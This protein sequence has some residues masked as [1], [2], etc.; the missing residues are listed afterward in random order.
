MLLEDLSKRKLPP[1]LMADTTIEGWPSRRKEIIEMF[2]K[3]VY[4]YSP[5]PPT[6]VRG[7]QVTEETRIWDGN[8]LH[9]RISINFTTQKGDFSFPI[10]LLTPTKRENSPLI[11]YISFHEYPLN[12]HL[13]LK[14]LPVDDIVSSGYAVAVM[15][16]N[17]V[18][19]DLEPDFTTGLAAMYDRS[20]DDGTLWGKISMWAWAASRVMDFVQ[21]LDYVDKKRIFCVGHS[22]LGKTALWCGVQDERFAATVSND[23]GCSGAAITRDKQ[24]ETVKDITT[25]FPFWFC[26]NYHKYAGRE[27]EMPFD[28]HQLLAAMAPRLLYVASADEDIWAD[29]QSEFLSCVAANEAYHLLDKKGIIHKNR[30]PETGESLH[31]G[32]IGYHLRAGTHFLARFDWKQILLYMDRALS[33]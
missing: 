18:T 4:G 16:Y 10:D 27:H 6:D 23:S 17:D 8:V 33:D 3:E 20:S 29:P 2:A 26:K 7:E 15:H 12:D 24:G 30:Y 19:K 13:T 9:Q 28:Q 25:Q 1:V 21:T 31:E 14:Y 22:R 32:K 11:I 5:I